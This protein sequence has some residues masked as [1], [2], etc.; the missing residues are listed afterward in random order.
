MMMFLYISD[1]LLI[2]AIG[3]TFNQFDFWNRIRKGMKNYL[4]ISQDYEEIIEHNLFIV[5]EKSDFITFCCH[6]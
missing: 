2:A 1:L 5:I 3:L 4:D 6:I